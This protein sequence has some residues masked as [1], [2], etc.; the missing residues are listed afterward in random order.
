METI[1]NY[2]GLAIGLVLAVIGI[3]LQIKSNKKKELVYSIRSNNL[4]SGSV[5]NLENLTITYKDQKI[6]NLTVSKILFF[7]RGNETITKQDLMSIHHLGINSDGKVL[8]A[9]VI[10]G[11]YLPNNIKLQHQNNSKNVYIDFDYLDHN[12]GSIIQII[13]TG[14][15]SDDLNVDGS[16]IG[17]QNLI[18]LDPNQIMGNIVFGKRQKIVF[19]V[20]GL[21]ML[22]GLYLN[23]FQNEIFVLAKNNN[24]FFLFAL[25]VSLGT[26]V[27]SGFL[28]TLTVAYL[29]RNLFRPNRVIPKGLESFR[30][31]QKEQAIYYLAAISLT[32]VY[33]LANYFEYDALLLI[34]GLPIGF[35]II[36]NL[37]PDEEKHSD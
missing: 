30:Y 36:W 12:H 10:E 33:Y 5:S 11:N 35:W 6:G 18:K 14:L 9:R 34:F 23:Y 16:I 25:F 24:F 28:L 13:H 17:V 2:L 26:L 8:N 3:I 27:S 37:R 4:I 32:I 15:S 31:V 21:I 22:V 19:A 7:N 29:D 20:M 1:I